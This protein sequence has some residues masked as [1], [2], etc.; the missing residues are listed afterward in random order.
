MSLGLSASG[1]G[2]GLSAELTQ[3][4]SREV[5]VSSESSV[6]KT[7]TCYSEQGKTIQFTVWQLVDGFRICD[8]NGDPFTDAEYDFYELPQVDNETDQLYMS[9]VEFE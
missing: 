5:T 1:W 6:T 4:F 7:F 3:T 9:V 8:S 2:L